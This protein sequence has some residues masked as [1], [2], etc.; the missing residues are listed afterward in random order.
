MKMIHICCSEKVFWVYVKKYKNAK[1]C[2][3][4]T[5]WKKHID[6][7]KGEFIFWVVCENKSSRIF[8]TYWHIQD[9]KPN[10]DCLDMNRN[11]NKSFGQEEGCLVDQMLVII[12]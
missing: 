11:G 3:I 7:L 10:S 12:C 2:A 5:F 6:K 1:L 9:L 4:Y 8:K